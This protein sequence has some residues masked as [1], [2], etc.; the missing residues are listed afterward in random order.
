MT[1]PQDF[2]GTTLYKIRDTFKAYVKYDRINY[3]DFANL[4]TGERV[5]FTNLKKN[6]LTNLLPFKSTA[7]DK[8]MKA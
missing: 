5:A 2:G 8:I 4:T 7:Q 6:Y 1:T 3:S